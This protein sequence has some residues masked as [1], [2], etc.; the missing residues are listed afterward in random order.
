MADN[1]NEQFSVTTSL[2]SMFDEN[3]YQLRLA[4]MESGMSI[5]IWIPQVTPKE[6]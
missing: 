1:K 4:G 2:I 6:R 3:G 5:A